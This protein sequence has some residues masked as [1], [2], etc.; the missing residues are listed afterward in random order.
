MVACFCRFT[1]ASPLPPPQ[2][3]LFLAAVVDAVDVESHN[4]AT[5]CRV[6]GGVEEALIVV[7][8]VVFIV[9]LAV[10]G[11][12]ALSVVVTVVR[13]GC[14]CEVEA[15]GVSG[16]VVVVVESRKAVVGGE[17]RRTSVVSVGGAATVGAGVGVVAPR[18]QAIARIS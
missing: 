6:D 13:E 14:S 2:L 1:T 10:V 18:L 3:L 4:L 9:V 16:T 5:G 15:V 11:L 8:V 17:E 12:C 7:V